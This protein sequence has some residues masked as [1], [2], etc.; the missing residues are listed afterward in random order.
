M[1]ERDPFMTFDLYFTDTSPRDSARHHAVEDKPAETNVLMQ[2]I[3]ADSIIHF[4]LWSELPENHPV[5]ELW[6]ETQTDLLAT[7]YLAYGGFFRQA[8][9]VLRAI[10][11]E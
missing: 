1:N 10:I 9:T 11:G 3:E 7:I 5:A 6:L 8:L 2:L 4:A